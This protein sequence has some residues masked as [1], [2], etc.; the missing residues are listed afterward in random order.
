TGDTLQPD[1]YNATVTEW[2]QIVL[3][4]TPAAGATNLRYE[5]RVYTGATIDLDD[6]SVSSG[7]GGAP[8]DSFVPGY[9]NL[10]VAGTSQVVTGL[11][12]GVTYHFRVRAVNGEGASPNSP[13]GSVVTAASSDP[14]SDGD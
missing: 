1:T 6:F 12:E 4:N 8:V 11:I 5:V 14:D 13:T 10:T 3:A 7:S 9:S 2:T